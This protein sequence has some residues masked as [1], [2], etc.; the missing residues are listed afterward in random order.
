MVKDLIRSV[1]V[2]LLCID[3]HDITLETTMLIFRRVVA[4]LQA[5]GK[6]LLYTGGLLKATLP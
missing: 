2:S 1:I 4:A 5:A 3:Q 6:S